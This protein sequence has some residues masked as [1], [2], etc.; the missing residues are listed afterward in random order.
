VLLQDYRQALAWF[1]KAAEQGEAAAQHGLGNRYYHGQGVPQNY[2]QALEWYRKAAEQGYAM[3]QYNLGIMYEQ[4]QGVPQS[5]QE[6][7]AW[8]SVAIANGIEA[9]S[10]AIAVRD[11]LAAKLSSA[12]LA[13]AQ[14]LAA[15]YFEQYRSEQ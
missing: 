13:E 3:S 11:M 9:Q 10:Q 1:R 2:Q 12:R 5:T 15:A 6:S 14:K 8:I 4:G 7:Y